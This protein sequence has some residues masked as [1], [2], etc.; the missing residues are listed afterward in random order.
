MVP[1]DALVIQGHLVTLEQA[2]ALVIDAFGDLLDP[3][4]RQSGERRPA[5]LE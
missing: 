1:E 3:T 4:S 2:T 5:N